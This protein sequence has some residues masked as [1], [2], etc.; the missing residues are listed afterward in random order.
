MKSQ[1]LSVVLPIYECKDSLLPLYERLSKTLRDTSF[2]YEIIFVEDAGS[3]GSWDILKQLAQ[4]DSRIRIFRHKQNYG[5]H[6]A[7]ASGLSFAR[8]HLAVLMDADLQDPPEAI[9]RFLEH[10]ESGSEIVLSVRQG[11]TDSSFRRLGSLILRKFFP[12]Y[13]RFPNGLFYGSYLLLS[14]YAIDE[15]LKDP[16]RNHYSIKVLDKIPGK[17][18]MVNYDQGF[19]VS[20][21]SSYDLSKLFNFFCRA[22]GL[23]FWRQ[24][25]FFSLQA[26]AGLF[27]LALLCKQIAPTAI[28]FSITPEFLLS[29]GGL[30][31]LFYA[32]FSCFS[33][34]RALKSKRAINVDFAEKID[35]ADEALVK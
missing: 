25:L 29:F 6:A 18:S 8:G 31:L 19:R 34:R 5:Q 17:F 26:A 3:D 7:V 30:L 28:F 10:F 22:A 27:S 4:L 21:K 1:L 9:P 16:E 13:T 12:L 23:A 33:M 35:R 15:Y 14:R 24:Q 32:A 2:E 20:G 11:R